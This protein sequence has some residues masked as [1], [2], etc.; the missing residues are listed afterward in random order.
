MNIQSIVSQI[1]NAINSNNT[2]NVSSETMRSLEN[3]LNRLIEGGSNSVISGK[4]VSVDGTDILLSIG[5]NELVKASLTGNLS[6]SIGEMLTLQ[7]RSASKE[8]I[9]LS[10]LFE[11]TAQASTVNNALE[12]AGLPN[13]ANNQYMV[14]SMMQE[15]L[16]IDKQSL[17]DMSRAMNINATADVLDLAKMTRLNIPLTQDMV[18]QF[19]NY[20]NLEHEVSNALMDISDEFINSI[21][22]DTLVSE[23]AGAEIKF[24]LDNFEALAIDS[25][26]VMNSEEQVNL[27]EAA[28]QTSNQVVNQPDGKIANEE[29]IQLANKAL[30][31][32]DNESTSQSVNKATNQPEIN[33]TARP[34]DETI[35]QPANSANV[36]TTSSQIKFDDIKGFFDGIKNKLDG[37]SDEELKVIK[38]DIKSLVENP[39]F[40]DVFKKAVL[41]KYSLEP[42]ELTKDGSVS[43]LYEKL[44]NELKQLMSSA[45]SL[46]G[47]ESKYPQTVQNLNNN[48]EFM[49]EL[50]QTF[51]YVQ[52]PLK[53][54]GQNTN[55]E[56]YVYKNKKSLSREDGTVSA[57]LHLDMDNLGPVDVHLTL[58]S[59]NNVKTKFYLKDD[60]ALDLI[61]EHIDVLNERL[62]KRGYNMAAEF[63]NKSDEKS[64]IETILDDHKNISL[65]S[66]NGFDARA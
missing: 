56:L 35:N 38:D 57:L 4:V 44:N 32:S 19:Q 14:K 15:G 9:S 45:N 64:V 40:K 63:I 3:G 16:S 26:S 25:E 53:L 10:P 34:D 23:D 31:Q 11:N 29:T 41:N 60:A 17:Y 2:G 18:G 58:N 39:A 43:K 36:K 6:T 28:E 51:N 55:G 21:L 27:N 54:A 7:V 66:Q 52:I 5:E 30:G 59:E 13:T 62:N 12:A 48:L 46:S 61:A 47:T 24:I 50:N 65:L 49:N 22:D 20:M 1:N 42:E 33:A 37:A 8:G